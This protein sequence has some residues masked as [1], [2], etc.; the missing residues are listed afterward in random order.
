MSSGTTAPASV[1]E[2]VGIAFEMADGAMRP[3]GLGQCLASRDAGLGGRLAVPA[4]GPVVSG[5]EAATDVGEKVVRL[6]EG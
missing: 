3:I 1:S 2:Q 6:G 5:S 4:D